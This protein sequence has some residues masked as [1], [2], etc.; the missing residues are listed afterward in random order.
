MRISWK[1]LNVY[2]LR[3]WVG[4][5]IFGLALIG[6]LFYAGIYIPGGISTA[7]Q[8]S[9]IQASAIN[10]T[11][12]DSLAVLNLPYLLLQ[13][14]SISV[15][16]VSDLSIKLPSLVLAFASG[17]GLLFLLMKWFKPNIGIL[18]AIIAITTGQFL[19]IAQSGTPDILYIFYGVFLLLSG[20]YIARRSRLRLFWKITFFLLVALSLYT[21][22]SI[23]IVIA[24]F[25][26]ILL[27]PHLRFV[28]R[29]L[30]RARLSGAFIA[31]AIILVPLVYGIFAHPGVSLQLLG[32]PGQ[33]PDFSENLNT[34]FTQYFGFNAFNEGTVLVPV[35]GLGSM[36]IIAY[37]LFN[38][39]RDRDSTHAYIVLLWSLFLIPILLLAPEHTAAAFIPM[40][41]MLASGLA[42]LLTYW[43]RL[44]PRNPYARISGLVP[45]SILVVALVFSGID[46]YANG[47]LYDP[48]VAYNF[49]R[50]LSLL[51]NEAQ[52][53]VV[54]Q[55]ETAFYE[56]VAKYSDDALRVVDTPTAETVAYTQEAHDATPAG[57]ELS[58]I[59]TSSLSIESDRFYVYKKLAE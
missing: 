43:Y 18:T 57:Y 7:E 5:S 24:L 19:F 16:G 41:I 49:S 2:R 35:F 17:I 45:I 40:V 12:L 8:H 30:S 52:E 32:F 15:L 38:F 31:S 21:P 37:G 20:T 14:A 58:Q 34:V 50:D 23:Y 29:S 46:R 53:L 4:Y 59:R 11:S 55:D 27:H 1:A 3:Y 25:I 9:V 51:P 22:L 44:F 28:L 13:K 33:L 42:S 47:Y 36:L 48:E 26:A 6:L 56:A 39:V 54:S 10:L